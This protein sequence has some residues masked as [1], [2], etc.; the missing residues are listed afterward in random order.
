MVIFHLVQHFAW[1]FFDILHQSTL[2]LFHI[3][4]VYDF[5]DY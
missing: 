3:V 2:G 5:T 4:C 1:N